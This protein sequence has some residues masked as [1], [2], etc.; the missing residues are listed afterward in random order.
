MTCAKRSSP[1]CDE[2]QA[3]FDRFGVWDKRIEESA[4]ILERKLS[5]FPEQ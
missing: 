4:E 5:P 1:R 3:E 2:L